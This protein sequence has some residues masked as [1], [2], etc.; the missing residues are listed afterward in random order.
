MKAPF[1]QKQIDYINQQQVSGDFHPY[2]CGSPTNIPECKRA[3]KKGKTPEEREGVLIATLEG[4]VCP[5]GK[6]IQ[7][8]A[9]DPD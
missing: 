3:N 1:T 9:H 2:T 5:C 7:K 4:L 6:Y 8:W